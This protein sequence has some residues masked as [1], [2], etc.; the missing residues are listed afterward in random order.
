MHIEIDED[1]TYHGM[2]TEEAEAKE[3][4]ERMMKTGNNFNT[5]ELELLLK[6]FK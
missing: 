3:M 2:N 4:M 5:K 6:T 1:S